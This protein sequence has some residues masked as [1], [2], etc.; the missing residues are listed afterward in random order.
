MAIN[1]QVVGDVTQLRAALKRSQKHLKKY[2]KSKVWSGI[3]K[4][5][6]VTFAAV[7]A[8][9][10]AATKSL[11]YLMNGFDEA[12]ASIQRATGAI[13]DEWE[14][15][16]KSFGATLGRVPDDM[17]KV[18]DVFGSVMGEFSS[19]AQ[20]EISLITERVLDFSRITGSEAGDIAKSI[21]QM[22]ATFGVAGE[23]VPA[24]LDSKTHATTAFGI[25]GSELASAMID[26]GPVFAAMGYNAQETATI[27]GRMFEAGGDFRALVPGINAFSLA[28][29]DV[30]VDP[31]MAL[32]QAIHLIGEATTRTEALSLAASFFGAESGAR[33]AAALYGNTGLLK[34][35]NVEIEAAAGATES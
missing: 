12:H 27:F 31:R 20:S 7:G 28:I 13:G 8:S 10:V 9:I 33:L 32:E 19:S 21:G 18:A 2:Q 35:L 25:E 22:S 17:A 26:Y 11:K 1:V 5:A 14:A 16:R 29:A 24:L 4:R 23:D 30:G 34:D 3:S 15:A 6:T